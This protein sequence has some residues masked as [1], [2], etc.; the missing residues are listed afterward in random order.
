MSNF[1]RSLDTDI[2]NAAVSGNVAR[3]D[4]LMVKGASPNGMDRFLNMMWHLSSPN[5]LLSR[6]NTWTLNLFS[7]KPK[8]AIYL[9]RNKL[10][11]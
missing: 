10:N 7:I 3:I 9:I 2:V 6:S 5:V 1:D 11:Y 8:K 4:E